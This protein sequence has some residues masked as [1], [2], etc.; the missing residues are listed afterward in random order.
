MF[1]DILVF[2]FIPSKQNLFWH[3]DRIWKKYKKKQNNFMAVMTWSNG[4]KKQNA[5]LKHFWLEHR[6]F[7]TYNL[8]SDFEN[9]LQSFLCFVYVHSKARQLL[10]QCSKHHP[11]RTCTG[12]SFTYP[13]WSKLGIICVNSYKNN[14]SIV[15]IKKLQL[16]KKDY[17][18]KQL[19]VMTSLIQSNVLSNFSIKWCSNRFHAIC[20]PNENIS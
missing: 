6:L 7:W 1:F 8:N 11:I 17:F 18:I 12:K 4:G 19:L 20:F 10:Y 16:Y 15:I 5:K 9:M 3:K 2:F 13:L 14:S